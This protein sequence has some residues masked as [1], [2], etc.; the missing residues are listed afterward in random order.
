M[1]Q[2]PKS[3]RSQI[4]LEFI[5]YTMLGIVIVLVLS[6]VAVALVE[7]SFENQAMQEAEDLAY[8]LQEELVL[9]VQVPEGYHRSLEIPQQL[10]R[11]EYTLSSDL[12]SFT[13]IQGDLTLTLRTP[14]L[15]GTL[16]KGHNVIHHENG[17]ILI[18]H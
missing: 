8:S 17:T 18:T 1:P 12:D 2:R 4:A 6:G 9:A 14:P 11:S 16:T 15:N 5:L 10:R 7:D 3:R 13:L